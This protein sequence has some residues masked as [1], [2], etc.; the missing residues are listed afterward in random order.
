MR[1]QIYLTIL[2][3]D[4]FQSSLR[5]K[6]DDTKNT[7]FRKTFDLS[8][9]TTVTSF[10][11]HLMLYDEDFKSVVEEKT[12]GKRP[13]TVFQDKSDEQLTEL[14]WYYKYRCIKMVV[15]DGMT[16][17][18]DDG[19]IVYQG[20]L[21]SMKLLIDLGDYKKQSTDLIKDIKKGTKTWEEAVKQQLSD[22]IMDQIRRHLHGY[23]A[24]E[25]FRT[26]G[27]KIAT[28]TDGQRSELNKFV[29]AL[30]VSIPPSVCDPAFSTKLDSVGNFT[31]YSDGEVIGGYILKDPQLIGQLFLK[32]VLHAEMLK[33]G[34][35]ILK[36]SADIDAAIVDLRLEEVL[37]AIK[38]GKDPKSVLTGEVD[39]LP[40]LPSAGAAEGMK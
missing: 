2:L 15:C 1:G 35:A 37:K 16:I 10:I 3:Q 26:W 32:I 13:N 30:N 34:N 14:E 8:K 38:E 7:P 29:D 6:D 27:K 31:C 12:T 39:A 24:N 17:F 40:G 20:N 33:G 25:Q 36:S 9:F 11:D 23:M 4:A 18:N 21:G 28:L 22:M 5:P 19:I